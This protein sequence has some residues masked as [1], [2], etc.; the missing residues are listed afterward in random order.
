MTRWANRYLHFEEFFYFVPPVVL[1]PRINCYP[2]KLLVRQLKWVF[3]PWIHAH[4]CHCFMKLYFCTLVNT[5]KMRT[6]T[7]LTFSDILYT[8][9]CTIQRI[10]ALLVN[11]IL[12]LCLFLKAWGLA[13]EFYKR[14]KH[15]VS[16]KWLLRIACSNVFVNKFS[17]TLHRNYDSF[18]V[19]NIIFTSPRS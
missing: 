4:V 17:N 19:E 8:Y 3:F 18:S 13:N 11:K 15:V 9:S 14:R 6:I 7:K 16:N 10:F 1:W 2:H 12:T 5:A